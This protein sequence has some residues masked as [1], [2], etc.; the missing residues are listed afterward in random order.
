MRKSKGYKAYGR[1]SRTPMRRTSWRR[2][3]LLAGLVWLAASHSTPGAPPTPPEPNPQPP[4]AFLF[5]V[6]LPITDAVEKS[7][8]R[9][10]ERAI[11]QFSAAGQA[12]GGRRPIVIFEFRPAEGASGESSSFG[13]AVDLARF[14]S[15]E[16]LRGVETVAWLPRTVKGHAVLPVLACERIIMA[17]DAEI[18][19]AGIREKPPIEDAIRAAYVEYAARHRTVPPAIAM[20]FVDQDLAVLKVTTVENAGVRYETEA[21]LK[22]LR[23]QGIVSK[24]D[25]FLQPGDPH[26]LSGSKMRECSPATQL[27]QTRRAMAAVVQLPLAAI[28]QNVAPDE[29]WKPLR[30]DLSGP[31]H[32]QSVNWIVSALEEH[33]RRGDFNLLVLSLNSGGGDLTESKRLAEHLVSLDEKIH[34]VAFVNREARSDAALVAMACDELVMHPLGTLGGRGEGKNLGAGDLALVRGSLQEMYGRLGRDWSLALALVDADIEVHRYSNPLGGEVRY[35][36]AEE[37]ASVAN[38]D[39]WLDGGP[40]ETAAGLTA[41]QADDLGLTRA[42]ADGMEDVKALYSIEGALEPARPN[43]V[44]TFVEWLSD[45]RI[46]SLLLFVGGFALLFELSTP[47]AI[48]PGFIA[49]VCFLLFFWS[50]FLHGTADW[51]EILLFVGGLACLA[52]ELFALPGFGVFGFGGGLMLIASIVLASQTFVLPTNTYQLRQFPISLLMLAAGLGGGVVSVILIR[53]FLPDTP[54]FNRMLLKPPRPEERE[55]LSRREALVTWEHLQNK[56]GVTATPLVPAGKVQFGDDL[57]DCISNG[58]LIAKG[59]PV[60]VE[61]VAGNRVVVRRVNS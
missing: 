8:T 58:E 61:E 41:E 40:V 55:A 13:E 57:V 45:P 43:W 35:L 59:T 52:V 2:L 16:R 54:Y 6:A 15:G 26:L 27:A 14:I 23:E 50:K 4:A 33:R 32:K 28:V 1:Q 9:R 21:D 17:K 48:A 49:V 46:A 10:V 39:E 47:G 12:A 34:T 51:L 53:R 18:G 42:S 60:V 25:A 38:I 11:K 31:M 20:A 24:E 29:G 56:R 44:L 3:A 22:R 37:A 5:D 30:I 36:S 7:V 19:A